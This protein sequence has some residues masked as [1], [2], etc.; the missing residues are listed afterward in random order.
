MEQSTEKISKL[1]DIYISKNQRLKSATK[2]RRRYIWGLLIKAVGDM[3][4]A[5]FGYNE[6]EDFQEWLYGRNLAASSIRSYLKAIQ[7]MMRWSWRRGYRQGD[8]FDGL[9]KPR[10]PKQEIRCYSEAEVFAILAAAHNDMWRARIMTA[11]S[12][13][14]RMG[15]IQNLT[16]TDVN[17]EQGYISVQSKKETSETWQWSAKNYETRRV[18]LTEANS[19]LI[20]R[21]MSELPPRQPYFMITADRYWWLQQLR[22]KG[23]MPDRVR[24]C[25]DENDRPWRRILDVT[26]IVGTFHD[27]RRTCI[28]QW[29][30]GTPYEKGLP[31]HE[32]KKLAGPAD[33]KTTLEYYSGVRADVIDRAR[34]IGA[35]GLEPATS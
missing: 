10:V 20:A 33:I 11:V 12:A 24:G 8:P 9:K 31:I 16:I 1:L 15:E 13:G 19:K 23:M 27:L 5:D 18:P 14:L 26:G 3:D 7:A 2:D 34:T 29:I 25:P 22:S 6:A 28:T 4:I 17:F 32:V 35:T 30:L 21:I